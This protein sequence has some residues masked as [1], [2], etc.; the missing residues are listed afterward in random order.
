MCSVILLLL[1][2][3]FLQGSMAQ[4]PQ[5][6][7]YSDRS[8]GAPRHIVFTIAAHAST[9]SV[10][11]VDFR[12]THPEVDYSALYNLKEAQDEDQFVMLNHIAKQIE[13]RLVTDS[14]LQENVKDWFFCFGLIK[15]IGKNI[16]NCAS[17][18]ISQQLCFTSGIKQALMCSQEH[19]DAMC[20]LACFNKTN[21][22]ELELKKELNGFYQLRCNK[23][24]FLI[25]LDWTYA[26]DKYNFIELNNI[27]ELMVERG[28]IG[29]IDILFKSDK[30]NINDLSASNRTLL[31]ELDTRALENIYEAYKNEIDINKQDCFGDTLLIHAIKLFKTPQKIAVLKKSLKEAVGAKAYNI[32]LLI[33]RLE[34]NKKKPDPARIRFLLANGADPE[35]KNNK[36][37][38]AYNVA[39]KINDAKLNALLDDYRKNKKAC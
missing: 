29:G 4:S 15:H 24:I 33:E 18:T 25:D 20:T 12:K 19:I 23:E 14:V 7:Q 8:C 27:F 17:K 28:A 10:E 39:Q 1:V 34:Q 36:G 22:E 11:P 31:M 32:S 37:M 16:P 30:F 38:N 13:A 6:F 26:W 21:L 9:K 2:S 5:K 35:I 3:T